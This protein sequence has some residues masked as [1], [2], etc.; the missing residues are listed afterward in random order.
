MPGKKGDLC[1]SVAVLYA[2]GAQSYYECILTKK[3]SR[4]TVNFGLKAVTFYL[5]IFFFTKF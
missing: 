5:F 1:A 3:I 4:I 2:V